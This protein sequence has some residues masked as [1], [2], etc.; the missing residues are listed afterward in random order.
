VGRSS[1]SP[2]AGASAAYLT[3]IETWPI[4]IRAEAIVELSTLYAI[5]AL[6][7]VAM[8]LLS[9]VVARRTVSAER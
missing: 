5:S 2:L 7:A 3:V 1:S 9:F 8:G 4:E 6:V